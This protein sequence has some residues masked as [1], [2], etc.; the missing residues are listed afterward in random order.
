MSNNWETKIQVE[1]PP[2]VPVRFKSDYDLIRISS[3]MSCRRYVLKEAI[4]RFD[5]KPINVVSHENVV[6]QLVNVRVDENGN[7]V[8]DVHVTE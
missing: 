7:L 3:T 2:K 8:G 4:E 6:G 5:G 1:L